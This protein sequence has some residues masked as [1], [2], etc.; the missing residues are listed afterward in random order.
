[1]ERLTGGGA[2]ERLLIDHTRRIA[3]LEA[4]FRLPS[5]LMRRLAAAGGE[6]AGPETAAW[7][8]LLERAEQL[9]APRR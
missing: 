6:P 1:M 8:E 9:R 3:A 2:R 4:R 5:D 7:L